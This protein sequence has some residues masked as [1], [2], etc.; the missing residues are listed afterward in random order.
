[1]VITKKQL[2]ANKKNAQKSTGPKDTSKT[3]LNALKHGIFAK[4]VIISGENKEE[5][6]S[7]TKN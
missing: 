5:F 3:K 4:R 1:M 7:S 6:K 2:A